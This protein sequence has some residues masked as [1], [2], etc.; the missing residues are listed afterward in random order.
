M[1]S[2][3]HQPWTPETPDIQVKAA[4]LHLKTFTH[5]PLNP[6]VMH[7][8]PETF[9][10]D[11]LSPHGKRC[12]LWT[13]VSGY[14]KHQRRYKCVAD[15]WGLGIGIMGCYGMGDW[16]EG[17]KHNA[18]IVLRRFSVRPLYYIGRADT[19]VTKHGSPTVE[20][21]DVFRIIKTNIRILELCPVYGNRLTPYY[22]GLITQMKSGCTLYSGITCRNVHLCLCLGD[23]KA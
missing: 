13:V 6:V 19:F 5:F 15:L 8:A 12:R 4:E 7:G 9:I 3:R 11:N 23:K 16:K 17:T 10:Q 20:C 2:N 22:M 14:P 21:V 18:G 1:V